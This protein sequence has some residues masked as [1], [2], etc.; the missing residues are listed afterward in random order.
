MDCS[1]PANIQ[2]WTTCN[3]EAVVQPVMQTI[4]LAVGASVSLAITL[5]GVIFVRKVVREFGK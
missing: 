3:T 1:A 5:A 4:E 2:E